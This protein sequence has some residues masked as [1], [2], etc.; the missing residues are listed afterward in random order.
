MPATNGSTISGYTVTSSPGNVMAVATGATTLSVLVP[1]LTNCTSYTFTVT[2]TYAGGSGPAS[3]PSSAVTPTPP[4]TVSY[5]TDILQNI[6]TN[7]T[8]T[9]CHAPSV[10]AG[11][12]EISY[13]NIVSIMSG[14]VT[15]LDYIAPGDPGHSYLMC[16]VNPT[17]P[18]C[19]NAGTTIIGGQMPLGGNPIAASDMANL[20]T[21]IQECALNN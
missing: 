16:K 21:W 7:Y 14:E 15:T 10:L 2:A 18:D 17:D 11:G 12:L 5:A 4:P 20:K 9:T 3:A 8:C 19:V 6:F 1:G 13:Q